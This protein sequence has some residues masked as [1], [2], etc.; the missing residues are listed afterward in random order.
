MSLDN[1]FSFLKFCFGYE[2]EF[3]RDGDGEGSPQFQN[4]N[5]V[6]S[7]EHKILVTR[8]WPNELRTQNR[9]RIH[10]ENGRHF[11]RIKNFDLQKNNLFK[12]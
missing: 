7:V 6:K 3:D 5:G 8:N 2:R 12:I 11:P 4:R 9:L 1:G 10:R